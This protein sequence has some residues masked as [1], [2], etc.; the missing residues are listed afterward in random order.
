V[1]ISGAIFLYT[2]GP[3]A[4]DRYAT[5]V[6]GMSAVPLK[7]GSKVTL[8][9]GSRIRVD[10]TRKERRIDLAAGEAFFDV[11]K[12][13]SRPFIV[14]AGGKRIVAV[15]T[16]FSVRNDGGSVQVVVTEGV[17][18]L[19]DADAVLPNA[20]KRVPDAGVMLT[21]GAIARTTAGNIVIQPA[22]LS[23]A[24][25]LLSWR[26]GYVVFRETAL[27]DAVAEFNRYNE[28]KIVIRDPRV[29]AMRLTGRYRANNFEGFVRLLQESFPI[30]AQNSSDEIVLTDAA[31]EVSTQ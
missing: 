7:D 16:Q 3:L 26:T 2:V 14:R 18:R 24:E 4:G 10:L 13:P 31:A 28:R 20:T 5:P 8:N 9:T 6:G 25:E 15:G 21:A 17:V 11:A 30:R 23:Q 12:D 27:A 1:G 19:E 22:S 29:A